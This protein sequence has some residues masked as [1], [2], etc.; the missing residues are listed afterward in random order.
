M[1]KTILI[2]VSI[3]ILLILA[4]KYYLYYENNC[5]ALAIKS[6]QNINKIQ[7]IKE[8]M[9]VSEVNEIMGNPDLIDSINGR[10]IVYKYRTI[11]ESY[12]YVAVY[13]DTAMI[14]SEV[15]KY[16]LVD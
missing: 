4:L 8:Q 9:Q 13:F 12:P 5:S 11:D 15:Y 1:K 14:V 7:L 16:P 10:H 6:N 2:I 3:I